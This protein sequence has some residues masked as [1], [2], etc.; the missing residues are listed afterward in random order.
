MERS[1]RGTVERRNQGM[2]L[3]VAFLI[4]GLV[5]LSACGS[6]QTVVSKHE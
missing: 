4:V 6:L 2:G 1:H 3:T 5:G